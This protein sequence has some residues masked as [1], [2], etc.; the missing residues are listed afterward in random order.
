MS[1]S[2][3]GSIAASRRREPA[4]RPDLGVNRRSTEVLEHVVVHVDAVEG[5]RRGVDLVE[6]RQVLV[7]EVRKGFG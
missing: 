6:V 5:G 4:E 3:A 1:V 7:N 2:R